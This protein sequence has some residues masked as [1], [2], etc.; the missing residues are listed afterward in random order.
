VPLLEKQELR[1]S[2]LGRQA[3]I[4]RLGERAM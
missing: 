1:T 4:G 3:G 2:W